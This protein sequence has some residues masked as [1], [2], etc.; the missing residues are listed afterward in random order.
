MGE[1]VSVVPPGPLMQV[2]SQP[3]GSKRRASA[4]LRLLRQLLFNQGIKRD[5]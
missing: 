2:A 4:Q 5:R 3:L 1:S